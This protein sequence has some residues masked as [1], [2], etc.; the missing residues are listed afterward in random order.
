MQFTVVTGNPDKLAELKRLIPRHIKFDHHDLDLP[1]IQSLDLEE[2]ITDKVKRAYEVLKKPVLVEDV[3]A[4]LEALNGLPGPFIKFFNEKLGKDALYKLA[5]DNKA[6]IIYCVVA[7]YDGQQLLI[8]HGHVSG[9]VVPRRKEGFGFETVFQPDGYTQTFSE[10]TD[11]L[12]D[13]LSHRG[14]ALRDLLPQLDQ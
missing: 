2:I 3:S 4:G 10:M 14:R 7:Y 9:Q 12:K 11:E 1:E 8:G 13:Q 6:T 5:G